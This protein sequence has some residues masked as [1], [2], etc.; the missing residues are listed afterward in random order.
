MSVTIKDHGYAKL[1]RRMMA[2]HGRYSLTVGVHAGEGGAAEKG[3][4]TVAAIATIHEFGTGR[5]P[6]RSFIRDWADMHEERNR[7]MVTRATE[8]VVNKGT[9]PEVAYGRLGAFF[10][11]EIQARI[12]NGI[13]PPLAESTMARKGSS[14]PLIDTGQL[15]SSIL[16]KLEAK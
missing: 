8:N 15:R 4:I 11:G 2:A 14:V 7:K 1:L 9:A 16:W 12:S 6:E 10:Q 13:P 5:I 3:G